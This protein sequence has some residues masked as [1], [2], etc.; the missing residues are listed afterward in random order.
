MVYLVIYHTFPMAIG[1]IVLI[2][3]LIFNR[4]AHDYRLKYFFL[5]LLVLWLIVVHQDIMVLLELKGLDFSLPSD[6]NPMFPVN[7]FHF[8]G[9]VLSNSIIYF[10]PLFV[11]KLYRITNRKW[12][13]ISLISVYFILLILR[14]VDFVHHTN[15]NTHLYQAFMLVTFIYVFIIFLRNNRFQKNPEIRSFMRSCFVAFAIFL[16]LIITGD[17]LFL[18]IYQRFLVENIYFTPL[19]YLVI[20]VLVI[21]FIFKYLLKLN[22]LSHDLKISSSL[23]HEFQFT[24]REMEVLRYLVV[25]KDSYKNI[26]KRLY[27]SMETVKTHIKHIYQKTQ[28]ENRENLIRTIRNYK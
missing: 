23:K 17:V 24:D 14:I 19:L 22:E 4:R 11:H 10:F 12:L 3:M 7:V 6:E 8:I 1:L 27:V 26:A 13:E 5:L 21:I 20:N 28:A 16:P 2:G 18:D 25:D 15:L 9:S